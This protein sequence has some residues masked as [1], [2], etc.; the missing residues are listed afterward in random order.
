MEQRA[1]DIRSERF[2]S[3][4]PQSGFFVNHLDDAIDHARDLVTTR[5]Y[6]HRM[7]FYLVA[8]GLMGR[9]Y[10]SDDKIMKIEVAF[11][12]IASLKEQIFDFQSRDGQVIPLI[13]DLHDDDLFHLLQTQTQYKYQAWLADKNLAPRVDKMHTIKYQI[14]YRGV[15]M[16]LLIVVAIMDKIDDTLE[17]R[18][19]TQHWTEQKYEFL[20][21]VF[22]ETLPLLLASLKRSQ[23]CHGDFHMGNIALKNN[24][25][26]LIDF[27]RSRPYADPNVDIACLLSW[28]C[29]LTADTRL[30]Y[31]NEFASLFCVKVQEL[32][33]VSDPLLTLIVCMLANRRIQLPNKYAETGLKKVYLDRFDAGESNMLQYFHDNYDVQV[34]GFSFEQEHK[35]DSS[36][37]LATI[38]TMPSISSW[39]PTSRNATLRRDRMQQT[40]RR[41]GHLPPLPQLVIP[42]II[43][44]IQPLQP[45]QHSEAHLFNPVP[46]G[47][48]EPPQYQEPEYVLLEQDDASQPEDYDNWWG[49]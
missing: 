42:S 14:P 15:V 29:K 16:T 13:Q 5:E 27:G 26:Q 37:S 28:F 8:S 25:I 32:E 19:T 12:G 33:L 44:P 46:M 7:P 41:L 47:R 1:R 4:Q 10:Q 36:H 2:E 43:Q 20:K 6:Q 38:Y 40:L 45:L 35:I 11:P 18:M 30:D 31:L 23:F 24:T 21:N 39:T 49:W 9:V 3:N 48:L 22:A 17:D 34:P